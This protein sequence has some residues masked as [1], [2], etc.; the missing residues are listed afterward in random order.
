M[1]FRLKSIAPS[2]LLPIAGARPGEALSDPTDRLAQTRKA[3]LHRNRDWSK[4][5]QATSRARCGQAVR[6]GHRSPVAKKREI[7]ERE[8]HLAAA[9]ET[10]CDL[11]CLCVEMATAQ[12][13]PHLAILGGFLGSGCL[14]ST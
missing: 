14:A 11:Y 5:G 1:L 8:E 7:E 6:E 9:G 3:S 4:N 12:N 10:G 2:L 13:P